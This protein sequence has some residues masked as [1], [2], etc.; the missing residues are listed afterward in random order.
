[1]TYDA[2]TDS[3]PESEVYCQADICC[4]ASGGKFAE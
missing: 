4:C 2:E 3:L 1:M